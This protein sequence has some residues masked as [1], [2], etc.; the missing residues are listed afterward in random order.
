MTSSG[1]NG[2]ALEQMQVPYGTEPGVRRS[3]R[4]LLARSTC[5]K[6]PTETSRNEVITSKT[7]IRSSLVTMSRLSEMSDQWMVSLYM[8]MSQ[9]VM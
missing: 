4:P 9:N 7:A 8:I 6:C 3:K 1:M 5:C 2:L